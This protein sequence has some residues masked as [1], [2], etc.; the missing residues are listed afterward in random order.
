MSLVATRGVCSVEKRSTFCH[1]LSLNRR[2]V[3]GHHSRRWQ[4][5]RRAAC[6]YLTRVLLRQE[7][8]G[9]CPR[10]RRSTRRVPLT[11]WRSFPVPSPPSPSRCWP[12]TCSPRREHRVRVLGL[13]PAPR[14][15]LCGVPGQGRGDR[16]DVGQP[17]T[18]SSVTSSGPTGGCGPST[19]S[20]SWPLSSTRSRPSCLPPPGPRPPLPSPCI[21]AFTQSGGQWLFPARLAREESAGAVAAGHCADGGSA[22]LCHALLSIQPAGNRSCTAG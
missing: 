7:I 5:S 13:G 21:P 20:G 9:W 12:S 22:A 6:R 3:A 1:W 11:G 16:R 4:I 14:R 2:P 19:P 15:P 8:I 10:G 17:I 18:A